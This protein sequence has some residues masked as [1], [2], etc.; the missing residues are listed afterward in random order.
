MSS[1]YE[2]LLGKMLEERKIKLAE[3]SSRRGKDR[4]VEELRV[5]IRYI[6]LELQHYQNALKLF[7]SHSTTKVGRWGKPEAEEGSAKKP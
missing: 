5:E 6:E 2:Q 7:R 3:L 4:K 1:E